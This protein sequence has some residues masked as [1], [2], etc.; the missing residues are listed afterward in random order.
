LTAV[1]DECGDANYAKAN[2]T[3]ECGVLKPV[4]LYRKLL[5]VIFDILL[6]V[7]CSGIGFVGL[8]WKWGYW[9]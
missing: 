8:L 6:V 5:G 3:P 7:T 9:N 4:N 2:L 1:N